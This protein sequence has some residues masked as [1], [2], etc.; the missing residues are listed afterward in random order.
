MKRTKR[1]LAP[2]L[3]AIAAVLVTSCS[4][5][6]PQVVGSGNAK[7]EQRT[8]GD[9][10]KV[11]VEEA[12]KATVMVGP[13]TSVSVTSDD[14]VLA[15]VQTTVIAGKLSVSMQGS[16]LPRTPVTVAITVP[17]LDDVEAASAANVTVTGVNTST[18]SAS[19]A[20]A[21]TLVIRGNADN[22]NVTAE[23]AASADLGGVPAQN[24]TV[25]ASSAARVTVN[26]Q[27]TVSGSVESGGSVHVQGNPP[28]VNVTTASGGAV[29]RD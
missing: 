17:N 22:V 11:S 3:L 26:A 27:L 7:T 25:K 10:T 28:S 16:V 9:F 19:S 24:A 4:S 1:L 21:A 8:V 20:S 29:V 6:G 5:I 12:I 18:F 13:D 23:S 2:S 14:N 15:N